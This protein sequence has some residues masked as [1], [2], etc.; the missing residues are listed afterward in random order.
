MKKRVLMIGA[1]A[2]VAAA[3]AVSAIPAQAASTAGW[4]K[5]F[6]KHYGPSNAYS[7]YEAV[8]A[9]S[10]GNAWAIGDADES[11]LTTG[12]DVAA[13]WNGKAW[14]T[15]GLPAAA[16][17][18]VMGT[19]ASGPG[20]VWAVTLGGAELHYN[21]SK[22]TAKQFPGTGELTGV[23]ALS[24]SNVWVFGGPGFSAGLGTWH[25]NG[26]TWTPWKTGHAAGLERAS[27]VSAASIWAIGSTA[28]SD[29][30]IDH[31]T[32]KAWHLVSA[33][34]LQGLE[35]TSIKAVS[36]RSV[37]VTAI[38]NSASARYLLHYNGTRWTRITAPKGLQLNSVTSDG[39]GGLWLVGY[40]IG[41]GTNK[42]YI[43]HRSARG[44]WASSAAPGF[45]EGLTTIP[46][47]SGLWA[48]G[49]V[50]PPATGSIAAIWAHGSV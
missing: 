42:V 23:T 14:K 1:A 2:T 26:K 3:V 17:G 9:T 44:T 4:R 48:S 40:G 41:N 50:R 25:Y 34:A 39:H 31:F 28:A 32:G 5:V 24:P 7:G 30:S 11:G 19:S 8:V 38:G 45:V 47:A 43:V 10:K 20:N 12:Q 15:A 6:S 16:Q 49:A 37:W 35:L 29:D 36:D 18:D 46:G 22:W 27:A 33:K 13:H 21:G